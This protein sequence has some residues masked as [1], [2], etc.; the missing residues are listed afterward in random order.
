MAITSILKIMVKNSGVSILT[1]MAMAGC[2][3]HLDIAPED[4]FA[5]GN[6]WQNETQVDNFMTG[7]HGQLRGQQFQ[8]FRLGE[9]RGGGLSGTAVF[10]VS[11]NEQNVIAHNM[12]E[13]SPGLADWAGFMNPILQINLFIHRVETLGFLGEEKK[14]ALL[15]QAYGI[16]AFYYFHL[17]RT[18]GGVPLRLTPDLLLEKPDPVALRLARFSESETL[19]AVKTDI[20]R[21]L[22]RFGANQTANKAYWT[23]DATRMLK[24]EVFL[25]SAK[26]YG[27]IAD[28][29]EARSALEAVTGYSL[30]PEFA[31]VFRTKRNAEIIFALPFAFNEAEASASSFFLYDLPNF[32]GLY[33]KDT[34]DATAPALNDPL[35][36][37]QSS[38]QNIQRYRYAYGLFQSYHA[39]DQRRDATFYDFYAIDRAVSPQKVTAR[40][41][42]LAKFLGTI[43]NNIRNYTDDWPVYREADRLLL[44]AEIANAEGNDPSG[45][46][47]PLRDRAFK[48]NDPAPFANA[49]Q[50]AN[51]IAIFEERTK[52]FVW[53]G[54]RWYD[55]RR[56]KA[57]GE[58][59][60]FK[61]SAHAYGLLDKATESH[62]LRWPIGRGVWTDDPLVDQTPGY[63]TT[64]P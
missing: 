26:V 47:Q 2:N 3:K 42:V 15:G 38:S 40:N 41:T 23:L 31:D 53:E 36:L 32:D 55:L 34:L 9:M 50:D 11:L 44:L 10:P 48:G 30:L 29:A 17:L 16:R 4:F 46:V 33:Y 43:N 24:G 18:Y 8:L 54:K 1:L 58:P 14:N 60:A 59:L 13:T 56:M 49:G 5:D 37:A 20:A 28:L 21:S 39:D 25:W 62:K 45:F 7:I 27:N 6:Y 57:G 52:E 64:K 35:M 12:D 19:T 51:E 22:E 61:S 63:E